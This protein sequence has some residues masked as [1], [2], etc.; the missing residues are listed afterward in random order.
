VFP[1]KG[2]F[3]TEKGLLIGANLLIGVGLAIEYVCILKTI[4]AT[5]ELQRESDEKIAEANAHAAGANQRAAEAN[6][7]LARLRKHLAARSLTKEQ[8]DAIQDLRGKI[9][10]V[11]VC[12][13]SDSEPRW[14]GVLVASALDKAGI[15]VRVFERGADAHGTVNMLYDRH[16]FF[17]PTGE[18]TNGE[19]LKSALEKAG[20]DCTLLARMLDIGGHQTHL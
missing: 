9:S 10:A 18:P 5:S 2:V 19:P 16:A 17:N 12:T 7:E 14:F 6:L 1:H 8:F 15:T 11:N 4:V 20:I 13:E 3:W